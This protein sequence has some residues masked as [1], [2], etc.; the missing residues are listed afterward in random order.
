MEFSDGEELPYL[1]RRFRLLVLERE[2]L[3]GPVV[4]MSGG[5]VKVFLQRAGS[6]GKSRRDFIRSALMSWYSV[7]AEKRI[8]GRV[9]LY[10]GKMGLQVPKV[11]I[12][13]QRTRWGS[14]DS[15]DCLRFNWRLMMAPL[16]V[17][18][19]VV[20]HELCHLKHKDH[21]AAFWGCLRRILPDYETRR[22]RLRKEGLHYR[23]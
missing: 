7:Q 11:F 3:T 2:G 6:D 8:P 10:A 4:S 21:A 5:H 12:R 13:A 1:G 15:R 20:V 23:L 22:K 16:D 9:S 19:Y 14:C 18:D 17:L